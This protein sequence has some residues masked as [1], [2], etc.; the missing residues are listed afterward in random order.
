[1]KSKD[2]VLADET[3][4][5]VA[6]EG[7]RRQ[8]LGY[9]G[10]IMLVKVEFQKGAIGAGH[11]H[12]HSQTTYAASGVFEFYIEDRKQT[13]RS[14]DG[15][16]VAPE[17]FHGVTCIEPGILIDVFSPVREDFLKAR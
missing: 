10:Q 15:V 11:K 4:W 13:I 3:A 12:Y 7:L 8:I 5:E 2:F 6:G 14:G 9:D 1:M 16:Y 17:A